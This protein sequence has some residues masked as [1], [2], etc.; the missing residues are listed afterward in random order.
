MSSSCFDASIAGAVAAAAAAAG[1]DRSRVTLTEVCRHMSRRCFYCCCLQ[2]YV[3]ATYQCVLKDK[4]MDLTQ[5]PQ[6]RLLVT[7]NYDLKA[8][9][10]GKGTLANESETVLAAAAAAPKGSSSAAGMGSRGPSL[11]GVLG[12]LLA[13]AA[14]AVAGMFAYL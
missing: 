5:C 7:T 12:A 8:A 14:A 3:N 1:A 4:A 10:P 11:G 6:D 13:A 9:E 2:E